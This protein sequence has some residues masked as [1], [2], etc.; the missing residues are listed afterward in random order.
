[1]RHKDTEN[2]LRRIASSDTFI[3]VVTSMIGRLTSAAE[4]RPGT[5][6]GPERLEVTPTLMF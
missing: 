6:S 5:T 1:M 2:E 3:T 4:T